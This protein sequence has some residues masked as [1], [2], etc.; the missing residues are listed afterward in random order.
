MCVHVRML[1]ILMLA[2]AAVLVVGVG[3]TWVVDDDSGADFTSIRAAE[4]AA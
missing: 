2:A 3:A 4:A 1:A